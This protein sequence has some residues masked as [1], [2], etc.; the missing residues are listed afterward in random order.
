MITNPST[1]DRCIN[2]QHTIRVL[3]SLTSTFTKPIHLQDTGRTVL[4]TLLEGKSA[5]A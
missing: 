3:R 5:L 1:T 4:H 2:N